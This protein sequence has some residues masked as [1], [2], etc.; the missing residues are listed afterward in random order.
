MCLTE[1]LHIT[2]KKR[3]KLQLVLLGALFGMIGGMTIWSLYDIWVKYIK[4]TEEQRFY[5][6]LSV[7]LIGLVC[8]ALMYTLAFKKEKS[9]KKR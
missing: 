5:V 4:P 6:D 3:E 8:I 2:G 1:R 7:F 9:R